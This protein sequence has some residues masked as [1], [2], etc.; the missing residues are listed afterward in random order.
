M[1]EIR[2]EGQ[3]G[4]GDERLQGAIWGAPHRPQN[5]SHDAPGSIHDDA[6]AQKLGFRG[7]TV[8]GDV[9]MDSFP[10]LLVDTFG[11]AWFETGSLSLYFRSAIE[12]GDEVRAAIAP[13]GQP[14][15]QTAVFMET[16]EGTRVCEGT[17]AVGT[18]DEPTALHGR[19]LRNDP[20]GERR[21]LRELSVGDAMPATRIT[22]THET[23]QDRF[24]RGYTQLQ[25]DRYNTSPGVAAPS[26]AVGA[27][28]YKKPR[29]HWTPRIGDA[30][31]LFGAIELRHWNGPVALDQEYT[32]EAEIVAM[33]QSPKTEYFWFDSTAT[34]D[35][36]RKIATMRM[37]LRFMKASSSLYD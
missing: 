15:A 34:D 17:A 18:P 20:D 36:G 14:G 22:V 28:L 2:T 4:H 27:L 37:M 5:P 25:L 23:Q 29:V 13:T 6:T 35:A 33:G 7:G 1:S 19:D 8:A 24:A 3:P 26:T 16:P 9:L 11:D 32:V 30:V 12:G 21:I 31:G 10:P